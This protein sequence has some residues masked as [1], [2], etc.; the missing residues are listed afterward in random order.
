MLAAF[1]IEPEA[2]VAE[3]QTTKHRRRV[4]SVDAAPWRLA[5]IVLTAMIAC[6]LECSP[7][8]GGA[9]DNMRGLAERG[10]ATGLGSGVVPTRRAWAQSGKLTVGD[11]NN[12]VS[13]QTRAQDDTAQVWTV[14]FDVSAPA[15]SPYR[16][17]ATVT[18]STNG[19]PVTRKVDIG[20]GLT[21]SGTAE[22][23]SVSVQDQTTNPDAVNGTQYGVTITATPGLRPVTS[24]PP[25]LLA[26]EL[27][28]AINPSV[29]LNI[30]YPVGSGANQVR[31]M[32]YANTPPIGNGIFVSAV[33]INDKV[34]F[35]VAN[36][37][38]DTGWIPVPGGT[39]Q[40]AIFVSNASKITLNAVWGIDG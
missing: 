30:P 35:A 5:A 39:Q 26:F 37:D 28:Q 9:E 18:F 33:D 12:T 32:Y 3:R 22:Q 38:G 13:M 8:A 11:S 21:I 1:A 10:G 23:V 29:T 14:Q 17:I 27:A 36:T 20:N 7:P 24:E 4:C 15:S 25:T 31:V 34:I 40:L 16:A 2:H 6:L 19:N